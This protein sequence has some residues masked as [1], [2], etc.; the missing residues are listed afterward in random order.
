[1]AKTVVS[2]SPSWGRGSK[3]LELPAD[4]RGAGVDP[5]GPVRL[6]EGHL[7]P[8]GQPAGGRADASVPGPARPSGSGRARPG[9]ARRRRPRPPAGP[10]P[11]P[12]LEPDQHPPGHERT[13]PG[14]YGA[15]DREGSRTGW[16]RPAV[17]HSPGRGRRGPQGEAGQHHGEQR[18][19]GERGPTGQAHGVVSLSTSGSDPDDRIDRNAPE[20]TPRARRTP[21]TAQ[22]PGGP[23]APEDLAPPAGLRPWG[24]S[25]P[26]WSRPRSWPRR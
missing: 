15:P 26:A 20:L 12:G 21:G 6:G 7:R 17:V 19:A 25:T 14:W 18:D 13:R 3:G 5:A 16:G 22:G 1:M 9:P 23:G 2:R 24:V 8:V 10:A 11:R 4:R